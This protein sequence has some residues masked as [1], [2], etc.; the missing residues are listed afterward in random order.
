MII[1]NGIQK[2]SKDL[3]HVVATIGNFDGVHLGHQKIIQNL[4]EHGKA[5]RLKKVLITFDP[6]PTRVILPS[7][8]P[9]LIH[10]RHQKISVLEQLGIDVL[11]FIPFDRDLSLMTAEEF[12]KSLMEKINF[13][14]IYI[15]ENFRFGKNRSADYK[16]LG[17]LGEKLGFKVGCVPF[18]KV[19]DLIVSSSVIRELLK[20]GKVQEASRL[21][22]HPYSIEGKVIP[23]EGRGKIMD[24]PTANIQPSSELIPKRG[25]YIS[26]MVVAGSTYKGVTNIGTRPTFNL[27]CQTIETHLIDFHDHI[28]GQKIEL[29]FHQKIRDEVKFENAERLKERIQRDIEEMNAFFK[30]KEDSLLKK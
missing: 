16:T 22:G 14:V 26:E 27:T 8:A 6:H 4:I 23:G 5:L 17:A 2:F 29:F 24:I 25:I 20:E 21:L 10:N 15:G 11:F 30:E 19:D 13:A 18:V 1:V 7:K 28:Y 12:L 9:K 3:G